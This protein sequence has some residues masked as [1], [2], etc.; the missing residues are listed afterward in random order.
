MATEGSGDREG[1]LIVR[2]DYELAV[3]DNCSGDLSR[4]LGTGQGGAL[5]SRVGGGELLVVLVFV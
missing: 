4:V 5:R 1:Q 3:K 2:T